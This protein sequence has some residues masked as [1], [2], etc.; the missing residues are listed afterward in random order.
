MTEA[1]KAYEAVELAK[2]TGKIKKGINEVTKTI[3]RGVAKL[4]VIATDVSPAEIILHIKPL[5]EEKG[6]PYAEVPSREELGAAAGLRVPTSAISIVKE[7]ETKDMI[8]AF[9]KAAKTV[10]VEKEEVPK[11]EPKKEEKPIKEPKKEEVKD[12]TT[13]E[14]K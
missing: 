8:K 14:N 11:E 13:T 2:K 6:I 4:V 10:I 1:N 7:G 5:C 12:E 3:E 9:V